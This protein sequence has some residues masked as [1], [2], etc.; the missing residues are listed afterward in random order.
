MTDKKG[1]MVIG[2][3]IGGIQSALDLADSGVKVYLVEKGP[4]VGGR[5][6]QLDKTFPTNDCSMCILS[7]KLV[8]AARH[9]NIELLTM[10]E[11]KKLEGDPG[12]FKATIITHPR[13]IDITKCV[14]CGECAEVCP[15]DMPNEFDVGT[16]SRSATYIPFPQATPLKYSIT[17]YGTPP[18]EAECPAGVHVQG[19]VALIAKGKYMEA[20]ELHREFNPLPIICGRVCPH[21]CESVCNRAE[22][23]E[24]IAIAHLKRFMA[25]YELE[26]RDGPV[27]AFDQTDGKTIAIIGSGPAGLTA[28]YYLARHGH[29]PTIYESLPVAG[30]MLRVGIPEYRL[31][32]DLLQA[33]IDF[34]KAKGVDIQLNK[35]LG[36]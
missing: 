3:G 28:A 35:K 33:E 29:K 4:S 27:E 19:Y 22:V 34:I 6:A 11:V 16:A 17:R 31:P 1:V 12:N 13:Y 8:A 15:I 26:N 25:A 23:D 32:R 7:P 21:T 14:G 9:S 24:P 5:M 2:G 10:S 30:G 20:L 18:C 36:T